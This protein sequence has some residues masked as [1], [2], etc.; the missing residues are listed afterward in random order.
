MW[1]NP[2]REASRLWIAVHFVV[3]AGVTPAMNVV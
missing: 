1:F 2:R 3:Y